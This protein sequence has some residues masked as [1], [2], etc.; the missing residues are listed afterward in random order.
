MSEPQWI[1]EGK[2]VTVGTVH[3]SKGGEWPVVVLAFMDEGKWPRREDTE[4]IRVLYVAATR[5]K[6]KLHVIHTGAPSSFIRFFNL[7]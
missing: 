5:T 2:G 3:W 1:A 6:E 4:E 7:P